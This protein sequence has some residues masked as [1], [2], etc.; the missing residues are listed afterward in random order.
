MPV[1][2]QV[3]KIRAITS[4]SQ[5]LL[6]RHP[7]TDAENARMEAW[8]MVRSGVSGGD[9]VAAWRIQHLRRCQ[10][11]FRTC[12]VRWA[13]SHI[14][15]STAEI[16]R[17][18]HR[19]RDSP[20]L[21]RSRSQNKEREPDIPLQKASRAGVATSAR[22]AACTGARLVLACVAVAASG[23]GQ[24]SEWVACSLV[25]YLAAAGDGRAEP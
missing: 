1:G 7:L 4:T 6:S 19:G 18:G 14:C 17:S 24:N 2:Y 22:R 12:N 9:F 21:P 23:S 11:R 25:T 13:A 5:L 20:A 10:V 16:P 8:R 15:S 3:L